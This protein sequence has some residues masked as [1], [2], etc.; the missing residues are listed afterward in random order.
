MIQLGALVAD[1]RRAPRGSRGWEDDELSAFRDALVARH[2]LD[3]G[4]F[5]YLSG[6]EN[7]VVSKIA[8]PLQRRGQGRATRAMRELLTWADVHEYVVTLTPSA[9][10]GASKAR[11]VRWYR[12]LGF[13][14]NL[15]RR[16]DHRYREAMIR[17]PQPLRSTLRA[18][19][20]EAFRRW[21]GR[22]RVVDAQG[23]PLVVY[24]GTVGGMFEAFDPSRSNTKSKTGAPLST[25]F[26]SSD[27]GI[28]SSYAGQRTDMTGRKRWER[29][30]GGVLPVFLS[31]QRPLVVNARMEG[32]R[33]LRHR[34][35][36][37]DLNTLAAYAKTRKYDGLV[38]RNVYD[39]GE[40][41]ARLAT[42]YVAFSPTQIKSALVNAGVFDPADPRITF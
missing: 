27:P 12:S 29:E 32:W 13:V 14:S 11:L 34:G 22:S 6:V 31:L 28:A 37:H 5:F 36:E 18:P 7:L 9:D 38:V 4:T 35:V 26:F 1:A 19:S 3:P 10:F 16:R 42:T 21:F 41:K 8:V 40:G 33:E 23:K 2:G 17:R 25:F 15:G 20:T 30:G 24:H 39:A